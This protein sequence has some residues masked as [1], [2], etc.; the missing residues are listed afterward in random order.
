[1]AIP[2]LSNVTSGISSAISG[3]FDNLGNLAGS[4]RQFTGAA[5][6][7][8]ANTEK[9][10]QSTLAGTSIADIPIPGIPGSDMQSKKPELRVRLSAL[11]PDDVLSHG[12]QGDRNGTQ[13]SPNEIFRPLVPFKGVLFP[14]TPA[15]TFTQAVNYM[16]LQ[17]VHSNTDYAAYTRTPS[18]TI[19]IN[20]KFTV[21]NQTEGLYALAC[22]HF[23]RTVSKSYFGKLDG[24]KAG[25]PPPV[26]LLDGYGTYI[27]NQLRVILKNHSWTFDDSADGIVVK[28]PEGFARIPALFSVSC[29]LVVVQ[30]PQR[31]RE[32]FS[33]DKFASG[34]LMQSGGWI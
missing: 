19:G 14:Y 12:S 15:I 3:G 34:E 18:V 11:H 8:L 2:N 26:L 16:D 4:V 24:D 32:E 25:L 7:T 29:E 13:S 30:T 21:Q 27:F 1:M 17:L 23:F 9:V 22:L 6:S 20:A 5:E 10:I 33:F 31:M 28:G